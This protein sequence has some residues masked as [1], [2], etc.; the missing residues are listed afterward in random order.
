MY[1]APKLKIKKFFKTMK[2]GAVIYHGNCADGSCS[3]AAITDIA[4]SIGGS[5]RYYIPHAEPH[6]QMTLVKYLNEKRV[7]RI[8]GIDL[9]LHKRKQDLKHL[10][11]VAHVLEVD[12]HRPM[13]YRSSDEALQILAEDTQPTAM[14]V[15]RLARDITTLDAATTD[16][17]AAI[18]IVGDQRERYHWNFIHNMYNKYSKDS[19]RSATGMLTLT[20]NKK[21]AVKT[22]LQTSEPSD[23]L[24]SGLM[25]RFEVL[26]QEADK[27]AKRFQRRLHSRKVPYFF[28]FKARSEPN[29]IGMASAIADSLFESNP[30][31]TLLVM[32]R[33]DNRYKVSMR[34]HETDCASLLRDATEGKGGGHRDRSG[35]SLYSKDKWQFVKTILGNIENYRLV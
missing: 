3:A 10:C 31:Y 21:G 33:V 28:E 35:A 6:V 18:G 13:L 5:I 7:D 12:H 20:S 16:W 29:N 24:N 8:I 32:Q 27:H 30:G 9:A 26:K 23:L 2:R 11:E 19:I 1:S 4:D 22:L 15:H 34:S 17:K 14:L 25:K